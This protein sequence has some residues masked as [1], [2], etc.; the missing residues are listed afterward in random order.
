MFITK[1]GKTFKT[2]FSRP[3]ITQIYT[4][5]FKTKTRRQNHKFTENLRQF[6]LRSLTVKRNN[7][8]END[9]DNVNFHELVM[10]L[11]MIYGNL[12]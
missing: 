10:N 5:L 6:T 7:D 8:D 11:R 2:F 1:T 12:Y 9:N 4:D 3:R